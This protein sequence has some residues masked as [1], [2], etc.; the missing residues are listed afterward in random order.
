[1]KDAGRERS[2]CVLVNQDADTSIVEKCMG[3]S[4]PTFVHTDSEGR[5]LTMLLSI[6][7]LLC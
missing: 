6:T 4:T 5:P 7:A 2:F 3:N 1:M